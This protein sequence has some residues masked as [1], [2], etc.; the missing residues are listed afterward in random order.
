[1]APHAAYATLRR[2]TGLTVTLRGY[3]LVLRVLSGGDG[4]QG[5]A[6]PRTQVLRAA[7]PLNNARP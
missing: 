2:L 5:D 4:A 1:M 3:R 7:L 6:L